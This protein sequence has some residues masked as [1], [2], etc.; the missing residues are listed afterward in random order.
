M[1]V[2]I[3]VVFLG[4]CLLAAS[5]SSPAATNT[6]AI[7]AASDLVFVLDELNARFRAT[8]PLVDLKVS[9]GS[10][11]NFF[12]Q[13]QR[14]APFDVFL[15]ADLRYPQELV[16]AGAALSNSLVH[17]ADGHIVLWT[18]R[19]NLAVTNG[20]AILNQAEVRR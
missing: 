9:T 8:H 16:R 6:V 7:A 10:S 1:K 15:S 18:T 20:L 17:Y 14:G 3:R 11:G 13:I 12:A 19:T 2:M 4:I 5:T